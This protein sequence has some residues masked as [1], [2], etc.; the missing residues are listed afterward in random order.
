MIRNWM[1]SRDVIEFFGLWENLHN[2]DFEGIE[3]DAF[4]VRQPSMHLHVTHKMDREGQLT[5]IKTEQ[6]YGPAGAGP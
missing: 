2:R 4:K 6:L 3:F 1:R 5:G